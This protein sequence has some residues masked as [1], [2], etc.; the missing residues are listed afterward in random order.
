M[1]MSSKE[2]SRLT[3]KYRKHVIRDIRT[4]LADLDS[5]D[6]PKMDHLKIESDTC[7]Y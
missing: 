6:G 1:T 2:I 4:M 3:G 7:D 5:A